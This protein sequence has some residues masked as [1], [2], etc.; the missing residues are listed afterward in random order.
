MVYTKQNK[1]YKDT[2][3]LNISYSGG[4]EFM[5]ERFQKL[6]LGSFLCDPEEDESVSEVWQRREA[7]ERVFPAEERV[8]A[9]R[10][11]NLMPRGEDSGPNSQ[12]SGAG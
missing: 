11:G 12:D 6:H 7:L 8:W 4:M 9:L 3:T 10:W 1:M 2:H 5:G